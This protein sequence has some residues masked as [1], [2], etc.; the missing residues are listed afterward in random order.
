MWAKYGIVLEFQ[1]IIILKLKG[2]LFLVLYVVYFLCK[3]FG[4]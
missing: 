3:S 4:L 2:K 1:L